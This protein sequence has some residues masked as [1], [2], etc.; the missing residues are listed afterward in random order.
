M[1]FN[2]EMKFF[3]Y[4][5]CMMSLSQFYGQHGHQKIIAKNPYLQCIVPCILFFKNNFFNVGILR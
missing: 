4:S 2:F 5:A 1:S 3:L